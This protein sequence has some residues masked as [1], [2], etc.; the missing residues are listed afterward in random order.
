[1]VNKKIQDSV[2]EQINK[3]YYSAYLYLAMVA[4]AQSENLKGFANWFHVQAKEE[5]SHAEKMQQY[6]FDQGA[7]VVLAAIDEPQVEFKSPAELFEKALKHEQ[8]VTSSIN[9]IVDLA[10]KEND[11]ATGIFLQ[12]FVTE[13][14]EEEANASEILQK[15][16]MVAGSAQG[17]LI[18]DAKLA[19]RGK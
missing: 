13:Q 18:M 15:L 11:H 9:N 4:Y 14:I 10:K 19:A 8:A 3:E 16:K 12:W 7:R 6:L 2:N 17:L 1:M 5:V